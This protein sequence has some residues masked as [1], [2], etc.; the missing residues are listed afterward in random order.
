MGTKHDQ[1]CDTHL[2]HI[3]DMNTSYGYVTKQFITVRACGFATKKLMYLGGNSV[4]R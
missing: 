4:R 3:S 2:V 1:E